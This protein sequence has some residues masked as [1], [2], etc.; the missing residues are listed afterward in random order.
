MMLRDDAP[1]PV[2]TPNNRDPSRSAAAARGETRSFERPGP[3]PSGAARWRQ[4]LRLGALSVLAVAMAIGGYVYWEHEALFPS[5][6][7]AYLNANVVRIAPQVSGAV[8]RVPVESHQVVNRG[9]LLLEIDPAPF[10]IA[11]QNAEA[12]LELARQQAR[13]AQA[14]V[15]AARAVVTQRQAA[16]RDTKDNTDRTLALVSK[17]AL[18]GAKG[19]DARAALQE[20]QATLQEATADLQRAQQELGSPGEHNAS[21]RAADAAVAKAKLDLSYTRITAPASGVLGEVDIRPG[22]F[23]DP[24]EDLFPLVEADSFWVDANFQETDLDRIHPGQPAMIT[25][26]MYPDET[27]TG[28][29]QS[30]SPASGV[31][32]SLLPP[33]NATGNW[34]K[35]TQRF[36]VKVAITSTDS[37]HPLR[38]GASSQVSIDTTATP[39]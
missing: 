17:G 31:A 2:W 39:R 20:A 8:A 22:S 33:E 10:K 5:T 23:V 25:V 14:A 16:L 4:A 36:P 28:L 3:K 11:L 34:V 32:F 35:V 21:I 12:A 30:V 18:P 37:A 13:A 7:D 9:Q 1:P 24:G 26:D 38:I 29:V 15:D 6:S 19:D 27:F